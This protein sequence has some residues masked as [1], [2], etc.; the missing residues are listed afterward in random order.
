MYIVR[1]KPREEE[2]R[3]EAFLGLRVHKALEYLEKE[4]SMQT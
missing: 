1:A 2:E 4:K 3:I